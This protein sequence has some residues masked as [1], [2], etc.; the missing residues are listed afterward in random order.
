MYFTL[1]TSLLAA[2]TVVSAQGIADPQLTGTWTSKSN[3]TTTGP[4]CRETRNSAV[5]QQERAIVD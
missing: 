4:V 2:A 5:R 3:K 1:T